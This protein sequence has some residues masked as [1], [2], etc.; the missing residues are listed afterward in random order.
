MARPL[1]AFRRSV[2]GDPHLQAGGGQARA[3]GLFQAA[4]LEWLWRLLHNPRRLAGRY[5]LSA[6]YLMRYNVRELLGRLRQTRP[7]AGQTDQPSQ[8]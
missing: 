1:P 5:A 2:T 6:L 7:T 8:E 3:P 4:G